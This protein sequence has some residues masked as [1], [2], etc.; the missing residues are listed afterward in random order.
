M[1]P[2]KEEF[3]P[4]IDGFIEIINTFPKLKVN[5]Y[6]TSTVIEGDYEYAMNALKETIAEANKKY[7]MAVYVT[8]IIPNYKAT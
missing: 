7:G 8:K 6:P 2:N 3:I 5:T 4:P 1:Y